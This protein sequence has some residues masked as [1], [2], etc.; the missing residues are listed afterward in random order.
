MVWFSM[1]SSPSSRKVLTTSHPWSFA[2]C[3][4]G[5]P[6]KGQK[7]HGAASWHLP[8]RNLASLRRFQGSKSPRFCG[9]PAKSSDDNSA[10][11][12]WDGGDLYAVQHHRGAWEPQD[13]SK[14]HNCYCKRIWT[15]FI[16]GVSTQHHSK[17]VPAFSVICLF[18]TLL[19]F[20]VCPVISAKDYFDTH[21]I[22][23][24]SSWFSSQQHFSS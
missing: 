14:W 13:V 17:L 16:R 7:G 8:Q 18:Y 21:M 20:T 10:G 12:L 15:Q 6:C 24:T 4:P 11:H 23:I 2:L 9:L 5:A 1:S 22:R 19:L 3:L